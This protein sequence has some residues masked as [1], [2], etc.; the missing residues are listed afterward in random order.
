MKP[1]L[2]F[3]AVLL[4]LVLAIGGCALAGRN[5]MIGLDEGVKNQ[6]SQVENQLQ[7]RYDLIPNLVNSVKGLTEQ[8]QK[9]F[10]GVAKARESYLQAPTVAEKAKA[11]TEVEAGLAQI[12]VLFLQENYPTLKSD[13]V[14]LKLMDSLE[15]TENRL[16]VERGKYNDAVKE[17]NTKVRGFPGSLW[18]SLAGVTEAE[19]FKV[20]DAAKENPKVDF[21]DRKESKDK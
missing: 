17:L 12:R 1:V 14:F 20:P 11:A 6:W 7:R 13:A 10:L 19:H 3:F 15:G 8:E 9:I 2:A 5:S 21:S 4:V 16:S 18:A